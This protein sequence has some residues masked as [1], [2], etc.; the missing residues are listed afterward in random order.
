MHN[1]SAKFPFPKFENWALPLNL[2]LVTV[3]LHDNSDHH[4]HRIPRIVG[5]NFT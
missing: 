1:A 5:G 2:L 3:L 4:H